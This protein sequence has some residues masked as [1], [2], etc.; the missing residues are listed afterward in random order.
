[1]SSPKC[2][3]PNGKETEPQGPQATGAHHPP[4]KKEAEGREAALWA[5]ELLSPHRPVSV[6]TPRPAP[7]SILQRQALCLPQDPTR[8]PTLQRAQGAHTCLAR[9]PEDCPQGS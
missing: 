2:L 5:L 9:Q 4:E 3:T 1:M 8:E 7:V 6:C